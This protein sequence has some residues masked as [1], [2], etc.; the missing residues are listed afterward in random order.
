MGYSQSKWVAEK[1]VLVARERGLPVCIYRPPLISGHSQTG[2][3]Y[4]SD[5]LCRMI[6]GIIQ[7]G[8]AP[9][10]DT[11]LDIS[12][13]DYVSKA[14]FYLSKQNESLNKDFH[15]MNPCEMHWRQ[16]I[17]WMNSF[18]YSVQQTSYENW[19][20]KLSNSGCSHNP[21][22]PLLP[23]FAQKWHIGELTI[24]QLYEQC[25]RPRFSCNKTFAALAGSN[26]VCPSVDSQLLN[27]YFSYFIN[28]GFLDERLFGG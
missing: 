15:L 13:V 16:F 21:L 3:W 27:T 7:M 19:L 20:Q 10:L 18:G 1:L 8:I 12:P 25:R 4:T 2:A 28:N 22:Y 24:P 23:F 26:I 5:F 9:D 17:D 6:K 14:I 11:T